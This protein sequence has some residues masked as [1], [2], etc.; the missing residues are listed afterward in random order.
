M[1]FRIL[2]AVAAA[3]FISTAPLQAASDYLLEI[4]GIPGE[5]VDALHPRTIEIQSFSLG[6]SNPALVSTG[7][8]AS[9]GK[10]SFSDIS[11]SK[12]LD[13][14][15]PLLYLHC[16]QGKHIPQATLYLRQSGADKPAEYY[17]IKLTDVLVTSVQTSGGG[18]RP[19]ES[20]SL[21]FAK[22]E[23]IYRAQKP[24][25]SLDTPV[26]SGWDLKQNVAF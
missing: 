1:K 4:E 12:S 16:A 21:N 25:G 22:I 14:S 2:F 26:R 23:F 11:F 15:S 20:L 5:S 8:G 10:V 17:V 24:D 9:S 7:G 19:M 6:A 3:A 13:K 18:D